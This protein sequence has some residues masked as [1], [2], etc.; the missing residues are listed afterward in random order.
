[1]LMMIKTA[2][3]Q[4]CS[5]QTHRH[6]HHTCKSSSAQHISRGLCIFRNQNHVLRVKCVSQFEG[7]THIS[8][9]PRRSSSFHVIV[10]TPDP[11]TQSSFTQISLPPSSHL[12]SLGSCVNTH[13][14]TALNKPSMQPLHTMPLPS[15]SYRKAAL[16]TL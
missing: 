7:H 13:R 8:T 14:P 15:R 4:H 16:T 1:M 11:D 12:P 9:S 10:I 5:R 2:L 6:L 3:P